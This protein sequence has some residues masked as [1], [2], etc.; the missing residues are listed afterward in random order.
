MAKDIRNHFD[1]PNVIITL[2]PPKKN[3][4]TQFWH[5]FLA[6]P[7][8][9]TSRSRVVMLCDGLCLQPT[10]HSLPTPTSVISG[11]AAFLQRDKKSYMIA[12]GWCKTIVSVYDVGVVFKFKSKVSNYS[13]F[14]YDIYFYFWFR[15]WF[16][17]VQQNIFWGGVEGK[18]K[19]VLTSTL[20]LNME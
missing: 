2:H 13:Y 9:M 7:P 3:L 6:L 18:G 14:Q 4:A 17:T 1:W 10:S 20:M 16:R 5:Q 11:D 12:C 19:H 8:Q 15:F